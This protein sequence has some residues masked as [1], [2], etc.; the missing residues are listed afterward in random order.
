M[1]SS[2]GTGMS[3][4]SSQGLPAIQHDL[5]G[6]YNVRPI[7]IWALGVSI[8]A[9]S[10]AWNTGF[11][12]GVTSYFI[13]ACLI[14]SGYACL[15]LCLGEIMSALPFAG[16]AY[17]LARCTLGFDI[18]FIVAC[19]E[20]I[21][22]IA[23]TATAMTSLTNV[24][25]YISPST[26]IY[27]PIIWFL[28]YLV[29]LGMH[30]LGD[31]WFWR[32]NLVL[33]TIS[34]SLT[35]IWI[36]GSIPHLDY[37]TNVT[38]D[39]MYIGGFSGFMQ[40]LPQATWLFVGLETLNT[41]GDEVRDPQTVVPKGQFWAMLTLMATGLTSITIVA[42]LPPGVLGIPSVLCTSNSGFVKM[43]NISD[44]AATIFSI[45]AIIGTI[46]GFIFAYS[47]LL[48]SVASSK[49][50]S[51]H[52]GT[53]FFANQTPAISLSMGAVLAYMLCSM[54]YCWPSTSL[55]L[56]NVCMLSA[57]FSYGTQCYGYIFLKRNFAHLER[58]YKSPFG[59]AG[60]VFAM[61]V[62]GINIIALSFFQ[63]DNGAGILCFTTLIVSLLVYYN[64]VAKHRQVFSEEERKILF[65]AH[66][67]RIN[68]KRSKQ[69]RTYEV[70]NSS[71]HGSRN[72]SA[73]VSAKSA[74]PSKHGRSMKSAIS[75]GRQDDSTTVGTTQHPV[76]ATSS[77]HS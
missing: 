22:Y 24:L 28:V 74:S 61:V 44:K 36:F 31:K 68:Q 32:T 69:K 13:G 40:A 45:N 14:A 62:F 10:L 7:D 60:A 19:C 21:E 6:R 2:P 42:G 43:F 41:A 48:T 5:E 18:G 71:S 59:I 1:T 26:T 51:P 67:A 72:R 9:Q 58:R 39:V 16:G 27:Q 46:F 76:P 15:V 29:L 3:A 20:I 23:Y 65:S 57:S 52:F 33:C 73:R 55:I 30:I 35:V 38:P 47:K 17:G 63:R 34:L 53:R 49:L 77:T 50:V 25:A 70:R 8:S 12:A 75:V 64:K 4:A 66:V 37:K 54:V 11:A 56:D